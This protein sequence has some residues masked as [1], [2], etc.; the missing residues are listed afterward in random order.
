MVENTSTT[1][2]FLQRIGDNGTVPVPDGMNGDW[3]LRD[4]EGGPVGIKI[5]GLRVIK[6][7]NFRGVQEVTDSD[8][9]TDGT[10]PGN[11]VAFSFTVRPYTITFLGEVGPEGQITGETTFTAVG[12]NPIVLG[13]TLERVPSDC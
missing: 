2:G 4:T 3:I 11:V 6:F 8:R 1:T 9:V 13:T 7:S 10:A 12:K 5:Q